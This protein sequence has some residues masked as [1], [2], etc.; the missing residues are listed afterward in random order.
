[1]LTMRKIDEHNRQSFVEAIS[2]DV[3]RHVFAYYD[4]EHEAEHT[5]VHAAYEG[6]TLKGYMLIYTALDDP[7]VIL[8]ADTETAR[9]LLNLTLPDRFI[10]H[11][12]TELRPVIKA[13]LPKAKHYVEAWMLAHKAK[14]TFHNSDLVRK[15]VTEEDAIKLAELLSTRRDRKP[16]SLARYKEWVTR[17]PTYGVFKDNQLVS[18]ASS[19]IQTPHVWMIGGV[20][21]H[22]EYRNRG[23][24][25]QATSAVTEQALNSAKSAALFVRAD[26]APAIR[27]YEK[28]GYKKIGE[29]IWT[30]Q[31][32]GLKP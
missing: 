17:L 22:P 20:F 18:Y 25:T 24:A 3:V 19:F 26:N 9:T 27:A 6:N 15:L 7:S 28:I 23:Y 30:D 1:M 21:T 2:H 4:L 13:K 12:P 32:T 8:E 14:A 29:K 16:S 10:M 31:G 5:T 11:S